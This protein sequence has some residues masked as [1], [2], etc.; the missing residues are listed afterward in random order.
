MANKCIHGVHL[1]VTCELCEDT[2]SDLDICC[3]HD[4]VLTGE[5]DEQDRP[6][7]VCKHC[8]IEFVQM[9]AGN[10]DSDATSN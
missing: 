9:Y 7:T 3:D 2:M 6:V 4:T 1:T 10:E 8:G 5:L